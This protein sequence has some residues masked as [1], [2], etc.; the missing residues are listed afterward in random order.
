MRVILEIKLTDP[1][2]LIR[3]GSKQKEESKIS[4]KLLLGQWS[5]SCPLTEM[6]KKKE[7]EN[8]FLNQRS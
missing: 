3:Y 6:E 2:G 4:P 1:V 8:L 5:N 7:E